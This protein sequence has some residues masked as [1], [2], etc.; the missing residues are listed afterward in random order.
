MFDFEL[1]TSIG[2][3]RI[4]G[5]TDILRDYVGMFN[6]HFPREYYRWNK[7]AHCFSKYSKTC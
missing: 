3:Y 7:G 6:R 1:D 5:E 2:E 4:P